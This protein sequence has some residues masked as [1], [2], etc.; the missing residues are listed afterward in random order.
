M[1][2][3]INMNRLPDTHQSGADGLWSGSSCDAAD[4]SADVAFLAF[5]RLEELLR[6]IH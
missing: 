1:Y 2:R 3:F 6:L 4:S 5:M